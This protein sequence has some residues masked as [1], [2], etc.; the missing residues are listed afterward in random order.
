[1]PRGPRPVVPL[2]PHHVI[3]RGNN[4]QVIF[5]EPNDFIY[6]VCDPLKTLS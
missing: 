1:M 4:R 2:M 3:H 6:S 5:A